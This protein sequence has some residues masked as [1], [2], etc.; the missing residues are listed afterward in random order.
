MV[1]AERAVRPDPV[2]APAPDDGREGVLIVATGEFSPD[3]SPTAA[4]PSSDGDGEP[5]G[6]D[7]GDDGWADD[8]LPDAEGR[9]RDVT[10]LR[11]G[12]QAGS[13]SRAQAARLEQELR[14]RFLDR[15]SGG[16]P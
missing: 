12:G 14:R 4:G 10:V 9:R 8:L 6:A 5:A 11:R 16:A 13:L 1:T 7:L 15:S 2:A 3:G